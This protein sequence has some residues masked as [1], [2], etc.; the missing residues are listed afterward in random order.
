[1]Q[2][3]E[4]LSAHPKHVITLYRITSCSVTP[5]F[6]GTKTR[7]L[8]GTCSQM[9]R[10]ERR[11]KYKRD[12]KANAKSASAVRGYCSPIYRHGTQPI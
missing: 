8:L 5:G 11:R 3:L 2:T 6:R 12:A 1:M 4:Q 7:A 9:L 10:L